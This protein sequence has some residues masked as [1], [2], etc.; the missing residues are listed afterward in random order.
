MKILTL[1]FVGAL[2]PICLLYFANYLPQLSLWLIP[3]SVLVGAIGVS[4]AERVIS[5]LD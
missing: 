1:R 4:A 3:L 2:I 5:I